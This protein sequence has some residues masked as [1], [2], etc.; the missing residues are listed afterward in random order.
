MDACIDGAFIAIEIIYEQNGER[1][2]YY[3]RLLPTVLSVRIF[4]LATTT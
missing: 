4:F 3:Y 1:A 2:A